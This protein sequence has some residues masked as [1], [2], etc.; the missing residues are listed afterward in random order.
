MD[1]RQT[2]KNYTLWK[3]FPLLIFVFNPKIDIISIPNYWQGI[4]L[5][6]LIILFYSIY[7]FISNKYKIYPNL[8]N[9]KMFGYNWILFFPYIVFSMIIGELFGVS[10][11]LM[12]LIRYLEYIALIIILNQLDPP[13]NKILLL[14]KIYIL[15]NFVIVILQY[16]ELIGG[17]T[18]RGP[19]CVAYEAGCYDKD[20]IKSLCFLNCDLGFIK[21]LTP[22]EFFLNKRVPGITGG[23]WE[24]SINLALCVYGLVILEKNLKKLTPYILLVV[25]MMLIAQSRGIIFG[26]MAGSLFLINDFKKAIKL[27]FVILSFITFVYLF[28]FLNF[29]EI[30]HN[31]FMIDYLTLAKI[32][33]GSFTGNLPPENLVK[34]TGLES[35]WIRASDWKIIFLELKKSNTLFIFGS[36]GGDFIYTESFIIRVIT[37]FGIIGSLIVIYLSRKLPLFFIGFILVTGITIDMFVSFKIFVF[38]CLVLML[39]KKD[40]KEIINN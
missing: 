10:P 19:T 36:G 7:F 22:P 17:F 26:F 20:D 14:F 39:L 27:F 5:D 31:R 25:T 28:N 3:L 13:K 21:N 29:K 18:S 16:F 15:L 32:I 35:M 30:V 8:I 4:R 34:G 37:S 6:D 38:S 12:I 24:L 9:S 33:I 11:Q 1:L 40:K 2:N 23:P